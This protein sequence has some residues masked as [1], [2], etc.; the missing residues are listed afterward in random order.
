MIFKQIALYYI[1]GEDNPANMFT[2][3]LRH[4]KFE[5]FRPQLGLYFQESCISYRITQMSSLDAY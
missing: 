4:V 2:T 5:T 1:P 3:N